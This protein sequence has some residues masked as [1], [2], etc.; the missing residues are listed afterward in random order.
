MHFRL[1]DN[2]RNFARIARHASLTSAAKELNLTKGA[3]SHQIRNLEYELGFDVLVRSQKGITLTEKGRELLGASNAAFS[4]VEGTIRRL[5]R[6]GQASV[7]LAVSSYFASRWL[8]PRL[9]NFLTMHPDIRLSIQPMAQLQEIDDQSVDLVIRW[10]NGNWNDGIVT[11]LFLCPAFAT[12]PMGIKKQIAAEG[13]THQTLLR[14]WK[15]STAWREWHEMAG[16]EFEPRK[17][18]LIIPDPNVR[19]QAVIDGQGLALNDRLI[20]SEL[21]SGK[22]ER[23]LDHALEDYGY[24]L[25]ELPAANGNPAAQSFA[26]WLHE[27]GSHEPAIS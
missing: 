15:G 10:G 11:C 7:T 17:D 26:K 18:S 12:G 4:E 20:S 9:M 14:D 22:M 23:I 19:V 27:E 3:L 1:Y 25:V 24:F 13:I 8:S 2:L 21:E 5:R 16:L 6:S